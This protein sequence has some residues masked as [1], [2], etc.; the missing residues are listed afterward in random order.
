MHVT[1]WDTGVQGGGDERVTQGVRLNPL[2]Y[3]VAALPLHDAAGH[4]EMRDVR[5]GV[6]LGVAF[7]RV[8]LARP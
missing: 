5:S 1:R 8:V 3:M 4:V 2:T 7:G 6:V